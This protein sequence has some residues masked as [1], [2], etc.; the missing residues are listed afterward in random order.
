MALAD[1]ARQWACTNVRW[2]HSI[3]SYEA[4]YD[5][6]LA[7]DQSPPRPWADV[8]GDEGSGGV[9]GLAAGPCAS[10]Q[11]LLTSYSLISAV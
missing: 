4:L 5:R 6:L 3:E 2:D 10:M 7:Q 9:L 1:R 8:P 11:I